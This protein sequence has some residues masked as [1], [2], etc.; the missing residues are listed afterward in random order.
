MAAGSQ[1]KRAGG[2]GRGGAGGRPV[3]A[4][5]ATPPPMRTMVAPGVMPDRW[6]STWSERHPDV[7]WLLTHAP[8]TAAL[9]GLAE[10]TT[11]TAFARLPVDGDDHDVVR[12]W[13]EETVIVVGTSHLLAAAD[14][15]TMAELTQILGPDGLVVP[16]DDVLGLELTDNGAADS[17]LAVG[18]VASGEAGVLLP[19]S[20]ARLHH[21]KD[22]VAV[23]VTDG[24]QSSIGL[25]WRKDAEHPL[26]QD[27]VGILR[28]RRANSSR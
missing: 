8:A 3:A 20:I 25:V 23:P 19:L 6:R 11:D 2:S 18:I 28:G 22:V 13:T 9:P 1:G 10:H 4:R 15:V 5:P 27:L 7:P 26:T 24:P 14:S 21:R 16:D 17:A 12:L